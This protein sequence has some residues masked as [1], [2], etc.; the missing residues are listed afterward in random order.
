MPG[1]LKKQFR[2]FAADYLGMI[3]VLGALV[4]FFGLSTDYFFSPPMFRMIAGQI[5]DAAVI[6]V[7]MTFVLIIRE[8]DLSVGSVLALSSAVLGVCLENFKMPLGVAIAACVGT[9]MACGALN[10]LITIRW[11]LPSFITT[12]GML[13]MARGG[14]YLLTG[15]RTQYLGSSIEGISEASFLGLPLPFVGAILLVVLGQIFLSRTVWGR[16]MVAIGTN[17]EAVRLSGIDPRRIKLAVF[18]LCGALTSLAAVITTS[19]LASADPNAGTGFELNAIAAVVIGGTSL[20]GGRGSV[21][22]SFFGVL[23]IAVLTSGLVQIGAQE[24]TKRL[25]TGAVIVAAVILDYY[26]GRL[27]KARS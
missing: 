2:S 9:G 18:M 5:P 17:E 22:N 19:R 27:A 10:A 6:A 7:G 12:L 24:P 11:N 14:A 4:A 13:E 21:V 8:I 20:M 26:R 15:S 25:V 1:E 23:I 3:L 16:Y